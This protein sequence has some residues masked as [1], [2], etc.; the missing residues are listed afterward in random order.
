LGRPT[1]QNHVGFNT[2]ETHQ[3]YDDRGTERG[4]FKLEFL[5]Y[6]GGSPVDSALDA[7]TWGDEL[8]EDLRA[9]HGD[10]LEV[11]GLAEQL[12]RKGNRVTLDPSRTDDHGNPV[13]SI[14]W[15]V[16]D[17]TRRT[18]ERANEIQRSILETVGVDVQWTIGP[19]NT[20]P[21]FHHMGTT[22]MGE[23]P[24]S[25]VVDPRMRTHDLENLWIASSSVFV[26]GGA[27]NPTLTIAALS[28]KAADHVADSL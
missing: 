2:T 12:P 5:N 13:P 28:L 20:G 4:A 18:I 9:D 7:D 27:L 25:S 14:E 1:R 19:D 23:A 3:F 10:F 6:A 26:T 24:E 17:Y 16:D 21:A 11:A 15:T 8:L 22:R